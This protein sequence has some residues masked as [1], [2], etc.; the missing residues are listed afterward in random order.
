MNKI[1]AVQPDPSPS[2]S[3]PTTATLRLVRVY[4]GLTALTDP[5]SAPIEVRNELRDPSM[6]DGLSSAGGLWTFANGAFAFLFGADLLYFFLGY[7][8]F[9][10][11]LR[12]RRHHRTGHRPLSALGLLHI[13]QKRTLKRKWHEDFPVLRTEGGRPGSETARIVAFL[14]EILVDIDDPDEEFLLEKRPNDPEAQRAEDGVQL[15]L[16]VVAMY[17]IRRHL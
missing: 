17:S 8:V 15:K 14:R 6:L 4:Q 1:S 13:F 5:G 2:S 9:L 10:C 3:G 16:I 11:L 7:Y 12:Y